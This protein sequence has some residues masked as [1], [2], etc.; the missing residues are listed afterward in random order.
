MDKLLPCP[1][2]GGELAPSWH[3]GV[4][5]YLCDCCGLK[6]SL[7]QGDF[8]RLTDIV[9]CRPASENKPLTL[10]ELRGMADGVVW[11]SD[12]IISSCSSWHF[13]DEVNGEVRLFDKIAIAKHIVGYNVTSGHNYG[14]TWVAYRQK[15]GEG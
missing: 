3:G 6:I 10:E 15:P 12:L 13:V 14:K 1:F 9:S 2:C 11:V 8:V 5:C 4:E 7:P